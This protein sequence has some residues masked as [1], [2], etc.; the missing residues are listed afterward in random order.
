MRNIFAL[1][2]FV[3]FF[4][5]GSFAQQNDLPVTEP[6]KCYAKCMIPEKF[7]TQYE[8]LPVYTGMEFDDPALTKRSLL[9]ESPGKW[10]RK[11]VDNQWVYC[12]VEAPDYNSLEYVWVVTDTLVVKEY[13]WKK[14]PVGQIKVRS[15]SEDWR[16][17]WCTDKITTDMI[18]KVCAALIEKGYSV[19]ANRDVTEVL[20]QLVQFQNDNGLPVGYFNMETLAALGL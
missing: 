13:E 3:A 15:L 12:L 2:A 14:L 8:L 20:F 9:V 19:P 7:E 1:C 4:L 10:V 5:T 18:S 17:V 11:M 6:G 16:Q